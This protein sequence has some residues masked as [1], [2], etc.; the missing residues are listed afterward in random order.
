MLYITESVCFSG[1]HNFTFTVDVKSF[2]TTIP[3]RDGFLALQ[4]FVNI[5]PVLHPPT[6]TLLRLAE[7]EYLNSF[8]FNGKH[9]N[10]I[11]GVAMGSRLGLNYA[12]L[13]VEHIEKQI[14][15]QY[16]GAKPVL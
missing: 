5:R 8:S 13:L 15:D 1:E 9:Y 10:Q 3:N 16:T 2:Y 4:H 14:F 12:C 11:G 6:D 7:L